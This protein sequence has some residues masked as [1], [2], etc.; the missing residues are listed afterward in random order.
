MSTLAQKIPKELWRLV[1][2]LYHD[3]MTTP[4]LFRGQADPVRPIK[5]DR[6]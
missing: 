6:T 1:D 4:Y 5:Y 2:V 3:G